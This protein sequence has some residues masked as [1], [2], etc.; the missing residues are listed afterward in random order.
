[1]A[2]VFSSSGPL[3][4]F[5]S[6]FMPQKQTLSESQKT[7]LFKDMNALKVTLTDRVAAFNSALLTQPEYTVLKKLLEGIKEEYAVGRR[8]VFDQVPQAL[9]NDA[10]A[11]IQT[12]EDELKTLLETLPA[13]LKL[14]KKMQELRFPQEFA[15]T[16]PEFV[17]F[18]FESKLAFWIACFRNSTATGPQNHGIRT[19]STGQ[20]Q[21]QLNGEWTSW[22]VI[23]TVVRYDKVHDK[24][25]SATNPKQGY[26]YISPMG[27]VPKDRFDYDQ[28]Y[29]IE[30][31]SEGE[32][33]ELVENA[34]KFHETNADRDPETIKDAVF[35]VVTTFRTKWWGV[36]IP[37]N[38]LTKNLLAN[39]P[40]HVTLRVVDKDRKVY[41][42]GFEMKKKESDSVTSFF[43]PTI[44]K[45]GTTHISVPDYEEP[46]PYE[47]R[48]TTNVPITSKR[49]KDILDF[50]SFHNRQGV[51]FNYMKQNCTKL[52][53]ETLALAGYRID[54]RISFGN[55]FGN[56]F[57]DLKDVPYVGWSLAIIV[58]A[59]MSVVRPIINAV[60]AYT[61]SPIK[62]V[63][64]YIPEKIQTILINLFILCLGASNM[65]TPLP[66]D[67]EDERDNTTK[68]GR[69]SRIIRSPFDIFR[70]DICD[71][72][73]PQTIVNWQKEQRS[74]K[75]VAYDGA[76]TLN[77][78]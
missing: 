31:L 42:F 38:W 73:Y 72:N 7:A 59:V 45:T 78:I 20:P 24:L 60:I 43:P 37:E 8:A 75:Q 28:I 49:A 30:Q 50:V 9:Y 47:L 53:G 25:V 64:R 54:T 70:D 77:L 67:A 10:Q 71:I 6:F 76:P 3:A 62:Q 16:H 48:T 1:M 69:F 35:Q 26:T 2:A 63:V 5:S 36:E 22:D 40:R 17:G 65:T 68:L 32:Y 57:P 66:D 13:K 44:L 46:K 14:C 51:R 41:S 52:T 15:V 61:P 18:L 55:F 34:K 23:Q 33:T 56:F 19:S 39:F 29:P 27:L 12:L 4:S 74:T 21:I 58:G 11:A